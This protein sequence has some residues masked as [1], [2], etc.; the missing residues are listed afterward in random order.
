MSERSRYD[1]DEAYGIR[2]LGEIVRLA[3]RDAGVSQHTLAALIGVDQA[4]ISKLEAGKLTGLRLRRLGAIIAVLDGRVE[5]WLR[6][7]AAPAG[8]RLPRDP[9][10]R[11]PA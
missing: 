8:R 6:L 4:V 9:T 1:S 3:R 5:Y 7:R 10:E 2:Q 11:D